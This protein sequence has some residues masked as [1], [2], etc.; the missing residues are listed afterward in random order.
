MRRR[1]GVAR[2]LPR[3]DDRSGR[4]WGCACRLCCAGQPSGPLEEA[5]HA[6]AHHSGETAVD[7]GYAIANRGRPDDL[8]MKPERHFDAVFDD[9]NR[10][11]QEQRYDASGLARRLARSTHRVLRGEVATPESANRFIDA[12]RDA[13][14]QAIASN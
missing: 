14:A 13:K 4:I 5:Q 11:D 7:E 9:E 1:P 6:A 8:R 3:Q 2:I 12:V 10:H